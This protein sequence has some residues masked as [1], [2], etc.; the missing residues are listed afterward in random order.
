MIYPTFTADMVAAVLLKKSAADFLCL[1]HLRMVEMPSSAH[2][3][4]KKN[5]FMLT[6]ES[7][8]RTYHRADSPG[9]P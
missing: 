5:R 1:A 8:M 4:N 2:D 6:S 3:P 7:W 9:K